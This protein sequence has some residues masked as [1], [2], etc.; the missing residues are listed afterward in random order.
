MPAKAKKPAQ[1]SKPTVPPLTPV[2]QG[3]ELLRVPTVSVVPSPTNPR[4]TFVLDDLLESIPQHG[5]ITPLVVRRLPKYVLHEPDLVL[6]EWRVTCGSV[7]IFSSTSES[8]AR[9]RAEMAPKAAYELIAGERRWRSAL[10]LKLKEVPVLV[11]ELTDQ[12][13]WEVQ[14]IENLQRENLTP[15]EEA[16]GF[17]DM[18]ESKLYGENWTRSVAA[19]AEKLGKSKSHV[20][21][22]LSLLKLGE[23][24][25]KALAGGELDTTL[26]MLV[27]TIPNPEQ[28]ATATDAIRYGQY[29]S[30]ND[31]GYPM[32]FREAKEYIEQNFRRSLK[33][34]AFDIEDAATFPE[35]GACTKCPHRIAPNVCTNIPCLEGKLEVHARVAL[36]DKGK[37]VVTDKIFQVSGGHCHML[38]NA[39]WVK[40]SDICYD[41]PKQRTYKQLLGEGAVWS[42]VNPLGQVVE[43]V[44]K[45]GLKSNLKKA[46]HDSSHK[47]SRAEA[48]DMAKQRLEAAVTAE[49]RKEVLT[50]LAED[51]HRQELELWR[52]LVEERLDNGELTSA[53]LEEH[54][55]KD[56]DLNDW[57]CSL[58]VEQLGALL[59][60]G[61]M[62]AYGQLRAADVKRFTGALG[63]NEAVIRNRVETRVKAEANADALKKGGAK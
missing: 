15:I 33:S 1:K 53:M 31:P 14:Q 45:D 12:Q 20:S 22:R 51:W 54:G 6:K 26:A 5:I 28:Q 3:G 63:I 34:V 10:E 39:P 61:A 55:A 44:A 23:G 21:G 50:L 41:D 47:P 40:A 19:L 35:A 2:D 18:I 56:V 36:R 7:T 8:E 57:M 24:A 29:G 52:A 60:D 58:K 17:Q 30:K 11:R 42:A 48:K 37:L 38:Y 27:A 46:G 9:K 16:Q 32:T 62:F 59:V 13:A 43:L 25:R 4:K 49:L